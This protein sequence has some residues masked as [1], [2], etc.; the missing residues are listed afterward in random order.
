MV[1]VR[2]TSVAW[3]VGVAIIALAATWAVVGLA[4]VYL[5]VSWLTALV[6]VLLAV[7]LWVGGRSVRRLVEGERTSMTPIGAARVA[8]LAQASAWGGS[9][10]VGYF[11]A[12]VLV[13]VRS[14]HASF[15]AAHLWESVAS[16]LAALVLVV[17]GLVVE[18]WCSIPPDDEG[19]SRSSARDPEPA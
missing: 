3:L 11:G 15:A 16:G 1:H 5:A 18:H 9:L 12:Q 2:R 19:T 4:D 17:V 6:L 7:A 8:A 10:V 13:A 14:W